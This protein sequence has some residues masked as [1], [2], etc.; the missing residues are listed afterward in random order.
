MAD[1]VLNNTTYQSVP[2][3]DLP[4]S[5]GG[6][7]RFFENALKMGVLRNDAELV[8]KWT[9][10]SLIVAD[11]E[12]TIPSR[13]TSSQSI[14]ASSSLS[15][16]TVDYST[17]A[18]LVLGRALTIPVYNTSTPAKTRVE[19]GICSSVFEIIDAAGGSLASLVGNKYTTAAKRNVFYAQAF[20]MLYWDSASTVAASTASAYGFNQGLVT[21]VVSDSESTISIKAPGLT[22]QSSSTYLNSTVYATITDVRVQY[23]IE[24]YRVPRSSMGVVGWEGYSQYNHIIDC[25]NTD[26]HTLT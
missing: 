23:V 24:L 20:R 18:Y 4:K 3:V 8:R 9:H 17:Y 1:V 16:E 7:A 2:A 26:T 5:G 25:V 19:Y 13:S 15:T 22:V 12:Y 11:D 6:T 21:P 14:Y 10:D